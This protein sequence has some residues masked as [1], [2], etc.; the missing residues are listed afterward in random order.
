MEKER[1]IEHERLE[2]EKREQKRLVDQERIKKEEKEETIRLEAEKVNQEVIGVESHPDAEHTDRGQLKFETT[3]GVR[4]GKNEHEEK[5]TR[6]EPFVDK[7]G[8]LDRSFSTFTNVDTQTAE[9]H[10]VGAKV[11]TEHERISMDQEGLR[12]R[13]EQLEIRLKEEE[14]IRRTRE[15][16]MQKEIERRVEERIR[17]RLSL[18]HAALGEH[19]DDE[20]DEMERNLLVVSDDDDNGMST[21]DQRE[22]ISARF[23]Q[24]SGTQKIC[25]LASVVIGSLST[26]MI[27]FGGSD[28]VFNAL[29]EEAE[30]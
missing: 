22:R 5:L 18:Q 23:T 19:F 27:F 14:E 1:I 17:Y 16:E 24:F 7:D 10:P 3:S 6:K 9:V 2:H 21:K 30:P 29:M 8:V 11:N 28:I 26:W 25:I 20:V 12:S 4:S 13:V 15:D